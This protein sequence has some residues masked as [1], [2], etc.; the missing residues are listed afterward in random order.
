MLAIDTMPAR[1]AQFDRSSQ[2]RRAM[3][4]KISIARKQLQMDEDDY[5]QG[6]FEQTGQ[7]SLTKCSDAQ[8]E[9]VL[10]W[11]KSKGFRAM[12][13][14]G[15]ASH[16]MARKARAMWISLYQLGVVHNASEYALEAFARRQL[17]CERLVWARQSDAYQLIEAL[18]SMA[19]RAG[20]LQ[21]DP[22]TH[23]QLPPLTLQSSL[24]QVILARLKEAGVAPKDWALHDAAWKLCG[25]ENT[26][27]TAWTA[28]DYSRLAAALGA[29]L[30]AHGTP[31]TGDVA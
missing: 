19:A 7:M 31:A 21:H 10:S 20:W 17:K 13:K 2:H 22:V 8:L 25:I 26:R 5:R 24:C 11:L 29:K 3:T 28:E 30:R 12:P 23:K 15:G 27:A 18:K 4:A 1:P 16:P 14:K 9:K 6:L